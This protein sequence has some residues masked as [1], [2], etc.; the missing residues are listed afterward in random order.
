MEEIFDTSMVVATVMRAGLAYR[1]TITLPSINIEFHNTCPW[2]YDETPSKSSPQLPIPLSMWSH[3]QVYSILKT[4]NWISRYCQTSADPAIDMHRQVSF[5]HVAYIVPLESM[6][7]TAAQRALRGSLAF[8]WSDDGRQPSHQN[9]TLVPHCLECWGSDEAD[10]HTHSGVRLIC[11]S[12]AL[13]KHSLRINRNHGHDFPSCREVSSC[14]VLPP[15]S[16]QIIDTRE[17]AHNLWLRF[18]AV[19]ESRTHLA[20]IARR[21]YGEMLSLFERIRTELLFYDQTEA[22]M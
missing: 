3:M 22:S 11:P 12:S 21:G 10:E 19:F 9:N 17:D 1:G 15:N 8:A 7:E 16:S 5:P 20:G 13:N 4:W 14:A 18:A 2:H 6:T